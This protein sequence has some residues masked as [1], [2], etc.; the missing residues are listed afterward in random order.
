MGQSSLAGSEQTACDTVCLSAPPQPDAKTSYLSKSDSGQQTSDH[1][2][3][4]ALADFSKT[5][6][7]DKSLALFQIKIVQ[8]K[9]QVSY[10]IICGLESIRWK[11]VAGRFLHHSGNTHTDQVGLSHSFR[12]ILQHRL[13]SLTE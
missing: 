3:E 12:H 13:L 7:R 6:L 5:N 11:S 2:E 1:M 4:Q 8:V 9:C 10:S